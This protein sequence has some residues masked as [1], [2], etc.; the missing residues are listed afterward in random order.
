MFH[1]KQKQIEL[2]SIGDLFVPRKFVK[3]CL[4]V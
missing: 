1:V 2:K 4:C 3:L